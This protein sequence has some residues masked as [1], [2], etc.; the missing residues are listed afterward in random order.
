[1]HEVLHSLIHALEDC[2]PLLPFLFL[3]VFLMEYLE[4][5]TAEQFERSIRRAGRFGPLLGAGLGCVPQCGFSAVCAEL[6]NGGLVSAG[7]VAA[8]FL[9]T[10][11]EAVPILLATPNGWREVLSL[12]GS[13]LIIAILAGVLLDLLWT[14]GKQQENFASA[15]IEHDCHS[16]SKLSNILLAAVR[17]T[18][19]IFLFLY[20]FTFAI[21]LAIEW[22]GRESFAALLLP[23]PLQP[24]IAAIVGLIPNCA[25]SVLLTQLYLDG[26]ISFGA[27][28]SGLCSSA[29]VGLLVLLRGKRHVKDYA[30][31]L[32]SV[33]TAAILS[34]LLLQLIA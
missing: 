2:L 17:R 29:G 24:V 28:I 30:I 18:V 12:I 19:E 23:G 1:M 32:G 25:A 6:F 34:G 14:P 15:H 3:T 11:D 7:T 20:L 21:A 9:S 5:R 27:A 33:L 26:M 4:H 10:S 22:I 13:K 16:D 8:V 31:L